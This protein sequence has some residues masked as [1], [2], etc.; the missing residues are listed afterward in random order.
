[1]LVAL[2]FSFAWTAE[3]SYPHMSIG[4]GCRYIW[5]EGAVIQK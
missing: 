5:T 2:G 4:E 3:G 1:V